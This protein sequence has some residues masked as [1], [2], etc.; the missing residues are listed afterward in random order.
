VVDVLEIASLIVPDPRTAK[1]VVTPRARASDIAVW[2]IGCP[3]Q[4]M[5]NYNNGMLCAPH[6]D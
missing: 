1:A 5:D 4:A 3:L 6:R 2:I